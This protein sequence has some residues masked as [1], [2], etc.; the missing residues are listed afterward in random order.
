MHPT[1][2]APILPAT[3]LVPEPDAVRRHQRPGAC[4]Q[5][6]ARKTK[7]DGIRPKCSNC[8]KRGVASCVYIDTPKPTPEAMEVLELL[9]S[10]PQEHAYALLAVWREGGDTATVLSTFKERTAEGEPAAPGSTPARTLLESELMANNP[11]A[12]P[13]L[14]PINASVLARSNLLHPL[15]PSSTEAGEIDPPPPMS[16]NS[17]GRQFQLPTG[18][19][20]EFGYCDERLHDLQVD[21]WTDVA[22]TNDFAARVISLYITTDHPLL[23]VFSPDLF[24]TDLVNQQYRFCSRFL[25]HALMYYGC[26][27]YIAFDKDAMQHGTEFFEETERLWREEQDSYLTMAGAVLFNLS[28]IEGGRDHG[29]LFYATQ[30]MRMGEQLGLFETDEAALVRPEENMSEDDMKARC[31]AAWGAFN[32]NVLIS[33]FYRQSGSVSPKSAPI[34]PIPGETIRGQQ[35]SDTP[36]EYA[37]A[38]GLLEKTFPMVCHFWQIIYG[39]EWI[40]NPGQSSPPARFRVALAEHTFRELVSWAEALPPSLHRTRDRTHHVTVLHI[41]LHAAVLD[42]FRPFIGQPVAQSSRLTTFS[43]EDSSPVSAYTASVNQL[44]HLIVEYRSDFV[45]STYSILWHTGLIYLSNAMLK[46]TDDPDWHL[47]LLL[48]IYGYESLSRPYRISEAIVEGLLSMAMRENN[49]T[50][51]EAHRIIDE[52]REGRLDLVKNECEG[53]IRANFM[54]DMDLA[55][56]DPEEARVENLASQFNDLALFQDFINREEMDI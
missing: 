53:G 32:C 1:R 3:P 33:L 30:A 51:N 11:R 48:C 35:E 21:F 36:G 7:C 34:L 5:C 37:A 44:K 4:T 45:A 14:R 2:Y 50:G 28:H 19:G 56:K 38:E 55:L 13:L 15:R 39:A 25:F 40:Y 6:R 29:V 17:V 24:I 10:L 22:I 9:K 46:G 54:L 26:Q 23:G 49:M 43:A 27:M 47:Y 52:L 20:H 31:Y 16:T 8:L 41:W 12:Y 18:S 42:V